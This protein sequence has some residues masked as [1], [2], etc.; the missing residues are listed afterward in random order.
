M[1]SRRIIIIGGGVMGSSIAYHLRQR[2]PNTDVVVLERDP[3]YA[4]ASSQLAMGGIRQQFSSRANI[5]LAQFSVRFYRQFDARFGQLG[6]SRANFQQRGYLFLVTDAMVARFEERLTTQQGLGARVARLEVDQI[7]RLVP[8]LMLDDI[9][10]G[11]FGPQDGYANPRAVLAGFRRA[12]KA[13][14]ATYVTGEVTAVERQGDA[15]RG[16]GMS[17]GDGV[18]GD[19]IIIAAG[20]FAAAVGRLAG[21]DLPIQPVRQQLFRCA[22]PRTWPYRFPVV[23]DPTGVHW[24]HEDPEGPTDTDRIVIART[25][26]DEPPGENFTCDMTR[27]EGDFRDPMVRRIPAL[28][29]VRLLEGWAGLYEMTPDHNPLIGAHPD[30]NGLFV[31]AGFSGHGL[32][33][34]PAV[35]HAVSELVLTGRSTSIDIDSFD[36]TRFARGVEFWDDAM[37]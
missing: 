10:F 29:E 1:S 18:V 25:K 5:Q 26:N 34:A 15:I 19:R 14:G 3:T 24:K 22:L 28:E 37:I 32:M 20:A 7:R 31:A 21:I 27:W 23:V 36:V 13:V 8:D 12:A 2:D 30:V 9:R 17:S 11:V 35:G 16:V 6:T 33:M 4:R